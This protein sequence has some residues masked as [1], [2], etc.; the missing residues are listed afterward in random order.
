MNVLL[1][2]DEPLELEQ[3]EF[4]IK[5]EFPSWNL[6]KAMDSEEALTIQEKVK[7]DLAFLD[8]HLP[9]QSGLKLA[10]A[11]RR[12]ASDLAIIIVTA[13]QDFHYAKQSIR[14]GV[15]EYITKP[16]IESELME[17]LTRY[18]KPAVHSRIIRDALHILREQFHEKINLADIAAQIHVNPSYLSRRFHEEVGLSFSEYLMKYRIERAKEMMMDHPDWN[19]SQVAEQA[20]FNS[21]HYFST[22]FRKLVGVTPKEFREKEK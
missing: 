22:I 1:V 3:L 13:F 18:R 9:G 16:V 11:L 8:I 5:P 12:H 17:V 20:G 7:L 21:L 4:L 19:I 14:L 2:D 6:Y 15:M 10:E